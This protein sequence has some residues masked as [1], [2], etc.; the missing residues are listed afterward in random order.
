MRH[1]ASIERRPRQRVLTEHTNPAKMRTMSHLSRLVLIVLL[2]KDLLKASRF[3]KA[4]TD[5]FRVP[6]LRIQ[7]LFS[8]KTLLPRIP[9]P[10]PPQYLTKDAYMCSTLLFPY[11]ETFTASSS[12][13][14]TSYHSSHVPSS[15]TADHSRL[16]PQQSV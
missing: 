1:I 16:F 12:H 10:S 15:H 4:C 11:P 2:A 8:A 5:Y 14:L 9:E 3:M 13:P 7:Q 6:R